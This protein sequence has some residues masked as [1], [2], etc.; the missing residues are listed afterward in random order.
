MWWLVGS[1]IVLVIVPLMVYL[2]V[3]LGTVAF[4][5]GKRFAEKQRRKH[6]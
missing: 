5:Q 2:C 4:F 3:R 1:V 6:G